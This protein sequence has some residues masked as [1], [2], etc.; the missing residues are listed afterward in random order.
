M[1]FKL[2][3]E[4]KL[5]LAIFLLMSLSMCCTSIKE[6]FCFLLMA[7]SNERTLRLKRKACLCH[8][9]NWFD[10]SLLPVLLQETQ[11]EVL[12]RGLSFSSFLLCTCWPMEGSR[13]VEYMWNTFS[14]PGSDYIHPHSKDIPLFN[15][16][17]SICWTN[18]T[19]KSRNKRGIHIYYQ[20]FIHH[21]STELL[22]N[23]SL[24]CR[25]CGEVPIA[26][27]S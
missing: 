15:T 16:R 13:T 2:Y 26:A 3:F 17:A 27:T 24:G 6:W 19:I 1:L 4:I 7:R 25:C 23:R 14:S 22:F 9:H 21:S 12:W 10:K 20:C 5:V 8:S 18:V 11:R